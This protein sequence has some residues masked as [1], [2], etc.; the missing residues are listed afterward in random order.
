[1][2][3]VKGKQLSSYRQWSEVDGSYTPVGNT[4]P[5][6]EPGYYDLTSTQ[7]G[8]FFVP[9]RPRTDD[10][11]RFPDSA[12]IKVLEG[13]ADFWEREEVFKKYGLPFKRGILLY[14]P[15]GSGKSCTLQLVSRDVVQRGG[16]VITFPGSTELFLAAYRALRDIQPETPVVVLMEDFEVTLARVNESKLLN[17]LDGVESLHKCVFLATTNYPEQLQE[18]VINR[19]SRFDFRVQ[20]SLPNIHMRRTY[21]ESLLQDGDELDIERY[22]ADTQGMSLAHV[23]EL[24]VAT[25]ILGNNYDEAARRLKDMRVKVTSFDDEARD[26]INEFLYEPSPYV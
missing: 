10:L 25:H 11:I 24:F 17:L 20:V 9:V 12:S 3:R 22:V 16:V 15:P 7:Q 6:I 26:A 13:I 5:E 8:M 14:G 18:R 2:A 23:K 19:P 4:H 21:L 1:M